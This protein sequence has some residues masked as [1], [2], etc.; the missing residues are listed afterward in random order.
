MNPVP[1]LC[2]G[3]FLCFR[4]LNLTDKTSPPSIRLHRR[5]CIA[6]L[7]ELLCFVLTVMLMEDDEQFDKVA[8]RQIDCEL[9]FCIW[10]QT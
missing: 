8:I 4:P 7:I 10:V 2:G 1:H 9:E 3:L 6:C 5:F